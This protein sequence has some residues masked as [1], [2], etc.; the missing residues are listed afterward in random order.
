MNSII[1]IAS[2][3]KMDTNLKSLIPTTYNMAIKKLVDAD[4]Y[5]ELKTND[6]YLKK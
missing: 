1:I 4:S 6:D 2:R 5:L 3:I